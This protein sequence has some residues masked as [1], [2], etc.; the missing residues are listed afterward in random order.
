MNIKI[1]KNVPVALKTKGKDAK[2]SKWR[3]VLKKMNV[4]DS[5]VVTKKEYYDFHNAIRFDI[6]TE[7]MKFISRKVNN[8]KKRVWR[9][10]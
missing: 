4:G 7:K 10:K 2:T 1:E 5:F 3:K 6:D 9:I 8:D